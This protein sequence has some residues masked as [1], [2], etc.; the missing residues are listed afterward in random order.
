M[1]L[2]RLYWPK[3]YVG[4]E[5]SGGT[6]VSWLKLDHS[7]SKSSFRVSEGSHF[8]RMLRM[9]K[10]VFWFYLKLTFWCQNRRFIGLATI[11]WIFIPETRLKVIHRLPWTCL[12]IKFATLLAI[13]FIYG[14]NNEF[15][16]KKPA[17]VSIMRKIVKLQCY[18][19]DW[20]FKIFLQIISV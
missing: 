3:P 20:C 14:G 5:T 4:P 7:E 12:S 10:D 17:R 9:V 19:L 16:L 6:L 8:E 11:S 1:N 18:N 2:K 15:F 13:V